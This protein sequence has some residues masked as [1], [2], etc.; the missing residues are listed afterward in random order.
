MGK[1]L[2]VTLDGVKGLQQG[3]SLFP[4]YVTKEA[5]QNAQKTLTEYVGTMQARSS[6]GPLIRRSGRLLSSWFFELDGTTLKDF[7]AAVGSKAFYST[8]HELGGVQK[9]Q[10]ESGWLWVPTPLNTGYSRQPVISALKA[11]KLIQAGE[12][13][14]SKLKN[15]R[16]GVTDEQWR[17]TFVLLKQAT[18]KPQLGFIDQAKNTYE[19]KYINNLSDSFAAHM[20]DEAFQVAKKSL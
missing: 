12:W 9:P 8:I 16:V 2:S 15:G 11:R 18:Y 1:K 17:L 5:Q 19:Q 14:Y 13:R 7:R 6:T 3:F 4:S 10:D 20:D